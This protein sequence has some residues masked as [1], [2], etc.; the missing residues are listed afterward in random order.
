[1]SRPSFPM[2][3]R[4][5]VRC[6]KQARRVDRCHLQGWVPVPGSEG[7]RC[8]L[9]RRP[10]KGRGRLH[11]AVAD[12]SSLRRRLARRITSPGMEGEAKLRDRRHRGSDHQPRAG[13][14][15]A[16]SGRMPTSPRSRA[17]TL[18]SSPSRARWLRSSSGRHVKPTDPAIEPPMPIIGGSI[19]RRPGDRGHRAARWWA[20]GTAVSP[21]SCGR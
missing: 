7:V 17:A 19:G 20:S 14:L 21:I 8:R 18:S 9:C 4:P 6:S 11:G 2:R 5:S 3:A 1:M 10:A 15:D 16:T 12:A 13:T